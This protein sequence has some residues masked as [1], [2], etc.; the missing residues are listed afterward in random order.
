[1]ARRIARIL[2]ATIVCGALAGCGL[3][4]FE[5]RE[6]WRSE[7]EAECL[8]QKLVQPTAYV[9]PMRP[10]S[11]PGACGMDYPFRV[12]A[13]GGGSVGL[14]SKAVLACPA[15]TT[16]DRW[17]MEVVQPAAELYF[18]TSIATVRSGSYSCRPMNNQ[19]GARRSEHSFGNAVDVMGFR[20]ADGR[21][22]KVASGWKGAL[23]EQEFLREV[24]VGACQ[25]FTTV[26]GPGSDAFHYDHIH[27]DLARHARGRTICKP[28]LKFTP[29]LPPPGSPD[30]GRTPVAA[31]H[32]S[33]GQPAAQRAP[34]QAG[35]APMSIH[36]GY[37]NTPEG[38][39]VMQE[40]GVVD[41]EDNA[42]Y[43]PATSYPAS[44]QR[45]PAPAPAP[46]QPPAPAPVYKGPAPVYKGPAPSLSSF[47]LPPDGLRPPGLVGG[48]S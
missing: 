36:D 15:L 12:A 40:D 5:K 8:A 28:I 48:R 47:G 20:F 33:Y 34:M 11:G 32:G 16:F 2:I 9:E 35:G 14:T 18:G 6:P 13:I 37:R 21:E 30:H 38:D 19:R 24:F 42:G 45:A 44:P 39:D 43:A 22:V 17:V 29:R 23:A 46:Y 25:Y 3:M 31:P 26:L 41:G 27:M 7:A 10:I 1:M 4:L